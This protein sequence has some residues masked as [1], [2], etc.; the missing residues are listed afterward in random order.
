FGKAN[1]AMATL[2]D[3]L[4]WPMVGVITL[5]AGGH[6]RGGLT[7]LVFISIYLVAAFVLVSRTLKWL[8][9]FRPAKKKWELTF[10]LMVMIVLTIA[11]S[12]ASNFVG[13]HYL[14]GAVIAGA[15]LTSDYKKIVQKIERPVLRYGLPFFIVSAGLGIKL[16]SL[17]NVVWVFF[18]TLT[19]CNLLSNGAGVTCVARAMGFSWREALAF[20]SCLS[21]KGIV[22]LAVAHDMYASGAIPRE[23]YESAVMMAVT[24]TTLT[25]PWLC[26]VLRGHWNIIKKIISESEKE[27]ETQALAPEF[28]MD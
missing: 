5:T 8:E 13:L 26:L 23:M 18:G 11:S 25:A 15:L 16:G 21:C 28:A 22:E 24:L 20:T 3:F 19:I 10:S 14:L 7:S 27:E 2:H 6:G 1:L 17:E 9:K 4:L 12:L